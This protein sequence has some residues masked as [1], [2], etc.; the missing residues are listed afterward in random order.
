MV[1]TYHKNSS[2]NK[3]VHPLPLPKLLTLPYARI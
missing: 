1:F 2:F 3:F